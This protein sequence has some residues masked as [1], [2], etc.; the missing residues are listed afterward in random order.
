MHSSDCRIVHLANAAGAISAW[1]TYFAGIYQAMESG[2]DTGA[3]LGAMVWLWILD[4]LPEIG[5]EHGRQSGAR[6]AW[7]LALRVSSR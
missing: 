7:R 1:L 3:A 5:A 4:D 6:S 2:R